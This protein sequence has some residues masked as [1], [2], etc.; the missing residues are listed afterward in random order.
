[1]Y[2]TT[3]AFFEWSA[4]SAVSDPLK[5]EGGY[6]ILRV[7]ERVP[8]S[9]AAAFNENKVRE[10]MTMEQATQKRLEYLQKTR[11]ESYIKLSENYYAGVAPLL[12]LKPEAIVQTS[13]EV[14]PRA[15]EKKGKGK[16]LKIFPKP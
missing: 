8:G 4:N 11:N 9:D 15:P 10:V 1:M 13:G 3:P 7:D 2:S 14:G 16:F 5:S 12:K 6:Q